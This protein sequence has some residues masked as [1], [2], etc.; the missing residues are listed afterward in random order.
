MTPA[1]L[2]GLER[3]LMSLRKPG[4]PKG[5]ENAK[6]SD[7]AK[8][9]IYPLRLYVENVTDLEE[10]LQAGYAANKQEVIRKALAE[11]RS[12]LNASA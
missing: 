6:K 3:W 5:N 11:A 10:L 9:K 12:R 4:A 7:E 2:M 8:A 1:L